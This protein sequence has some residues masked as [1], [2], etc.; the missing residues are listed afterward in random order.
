MQITCISHGSGSRGGRLL[1]VEHGTQKRKSSGCIYMGVSFGTA[2]SVV[3][4][5]DRIQS[6]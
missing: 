6:R 3:L 2:R 1:G 5:G 4:R